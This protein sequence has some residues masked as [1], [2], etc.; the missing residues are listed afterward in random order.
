MKMNVVRIK[1]YVQDKSLPRE[2]RLKSILESW[3]QEELARQIGQMQLQN[4]VLMEYVFELT[5]RIKNLETLSRGDALSHQA[6]AGA[7]GDPQ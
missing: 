1:D 3:Q 4:E 6:Q 2:A 7:S 5:W